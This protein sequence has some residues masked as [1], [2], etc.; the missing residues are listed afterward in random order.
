MIHGADDERQVEIMCECAVTQC[1]DMVQL[2]KAQYAAVR[3][4]PIR[5]IVLPE[6]VLEATERVVERTERY[7]VIEKVGASADEA[8]SLR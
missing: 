8:A 1:R 2:R 4:S 7:W 5:F 6:H 3:A